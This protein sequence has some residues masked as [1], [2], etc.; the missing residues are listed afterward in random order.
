MSSS[1]SSNTTEIAINVVFGITATIISI[2]TVWQGHKVWKMW[3]GYT[4]DPESVAPDIELGL[5]SSESTP[6]TPEGR[7]LGNVIA[8]SAPSADQD[9]GAA[10]VPI[11]VQIPRIQRGVPTLGDALTILGPDL[12]Q[13]AQ[14]DGNEVPGHRV[15]NEYPVSSSPSPDLALQGWLDGEEGPGGQV[16]NQC[17]VSVSPSSDL[18]QGSWVDGNEVSESRIENEHAASTLME[19]QEV[20][21]TATS[22][23]DP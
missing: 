16:E 1:A 17:P 19:R 3:R 6:P 8:T 11:P 7:D 15:E 5:A 4:H 12:D 21:V 14:V 2:V 10:P 18:V 23:S 22:I 9:G 13:R 20:H